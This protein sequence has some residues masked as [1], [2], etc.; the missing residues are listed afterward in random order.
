[1]GALHLFLA[2]D[3]PDIK[4]GLLQTLS[5]IFMGI[6]AVFGV[7]V[8]ILYFRFAFADTGEKRAKEKRRIIMAASALILIIVLAGLLQILEFNYNQEKGKDEVRESDY[9][10]DPDGVA[11]PEAGGFLE[12]L[13][14]GGEPLVTAGGDGQ[15]VELIK[16]YVAA[17]TGLDY[18]KMILGNG[19]L[20]A[21]GVVSVAADKFQMTTYSATNLPQ[22]GDILSFDYTAAN[23]FGHTAIVYSVNPNGTM[24]VVHQNI[25]TKYNSRNGEKIA[26]P[27]TN[28][29]SLEAN[30][31]W[32]N[33]PS[34]RRIVG[35]AR[36]VS[37]AG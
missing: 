24:T 34:N 13:K 20:T 10:Y 19:N 12:N 5:Y 18:N 21:S 36:L 30:I 23:Q 26:I 9:G 25:T 27:G 35:V 22:A 17:I 1:M 8:A 4:T 15:C 33:P 32:T 37:D 14:I 11:N 7:F 2:D 16:Y 29:I 28:K 31:S 6:S 3:T